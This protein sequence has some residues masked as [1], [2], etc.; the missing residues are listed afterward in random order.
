MKLRSLGK[1]LEK[2]REKE[3]GALSEKDSAEWNAA[4]P[5]GLGYNPLVCPVN[6]SYFSIS[7][8]FTSSAPFKLV[9]IFLRN[10]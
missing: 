10:L 9:L 3:R 8:T 4:Y 2:G 5:F 7:F 6:S 1:K